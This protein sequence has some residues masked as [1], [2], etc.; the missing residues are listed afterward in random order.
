MKNISTFDEFKHAVI[1]EVSSQRFMVYDAI[2]KACARIGDIFDTATISPSIG[3]NTELYLSWLDQEYKQRFEEH[4]HD[5]QYTQSL[6]KEAA[7]KIRTIL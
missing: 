6:L 4:K 3:L 1:K 5:P 2:F 7:N